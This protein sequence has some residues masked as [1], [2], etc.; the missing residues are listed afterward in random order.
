MWN[1]GHSVNLSVT[2]ILLQVP[3]RYGVGEHVELEIDFLGLPKMKTT[4][5]SVG[6]V[7]RED[8]AVSGAAIQFD[9]QGLP[10]R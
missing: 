6:R 5:R 10:A 8:P 3:H 2:G 7:V 1:T 9:L 4:I